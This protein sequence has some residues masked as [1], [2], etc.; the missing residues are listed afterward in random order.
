MLKFSMFRKL[1]FISVILMLALGSTAV[2]AQ[3]LD[4]RTIS[5]IKVKFINANKYFD[6]KSYDKAL[7]KVVEIEGL[8]GDKPS[9]TALNLK[10]KIMVA[11]GQF[12]EADQALNNLYGLNLSN[13]ILNDISEYSPTL[14]ANLKQ[15]KAREAAILQKQREKAAAQAV[16]VRAKNAQR[17][18]IRD[19]YKKN[20]GD[21]SQVVTY[22]QGRLW[23]FVNKTGEIIHPFVYKKLENYGSEILV[24]TRTPLRNEEYT[25]CYLLNLKGDILV[26]GQEG[27][28]CSSKHGYIHVLREPKKSRDNYDSWVYD[29]KLRVISRNGSMISREWLVTSSREKYASCFR[30]VSTSN[31]FCKA[32]LKNGKRWNISSAWYSH[33]PMQDYLLVG[34]LN[35]TNGKKSPKDDVVLLNKH[36]VQVGRRYKRIEKRDDVA[37]VSK[38][39]SGANLTKF[40]LSYH[41]K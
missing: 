39:S 14:E 6:E 13:E 4:A 23:G 18:A 24:A 34:E 35:R 17:Q 10:I 41:L 8:L 27:Y 40:S 28:D 32:T 37:Y 31:R 1:K 7:A 2:C 20:H 30:H 15:Q 19:W 16:Q 22:K 11:R 9:P 33:F 12:I 29:T 5:I 3:S 38:K 26:R 21:S 36:G 25:R